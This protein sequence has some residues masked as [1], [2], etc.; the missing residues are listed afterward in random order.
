[1]PTS[2]SKIF[3]DKDYQKAKK[4]PRNLNI[5]DFLCCNFKISTPQFLQAVLRIQSTPDGYQMSMS[6][7]PWVCL[8]DPEVLCAA[9]KNLNGLHS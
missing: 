9:H 7:N 5:L 8:Q 4:A 6:C 2:W 1:M 3:D